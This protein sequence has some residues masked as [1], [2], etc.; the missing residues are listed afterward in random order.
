MGIW[1]TKDAAQATTFG[2]KPG[3]IRVKDQNGDGK[4]DTQ[5]DRIILG[6][7]RPKWSGGLDNSIS[8]KGF[9]VNIF[10][11]A[12]I[13]QMINA[14]RYA[15]FDQQ[16]TGNSTSGLDYW[17]PENATND[18]PRPT[19]NGGLLYLSTLAYQNGSFARI[20]NISLGYTVPS[21]LLQ[22]GFIK[23]FRAYVTGKNLYTFTDL[24]YDPERGGSENFPMTKLFV[25]GLNLTL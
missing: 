12:R 1:Q 15:R 17:T 22:K 4:I 16:A 19:K 18:Y 2:A 5:N 25:F 10:V 6:N 11:F 9:D 8:Y 7:P 20:R 23:G 24:N 14:D 13:G 21:K 3:E